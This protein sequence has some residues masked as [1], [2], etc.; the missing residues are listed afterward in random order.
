MTY[1]AIAAGL[2][3]LIFGFVV[4]QRIQATRCHRCRFWKATRGQQSVGRCHVETT[5]PHIVHR[6]GTCEEWEGR[7]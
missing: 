5:F 4:W 3:L 6:T 1:I 7:I 2:M